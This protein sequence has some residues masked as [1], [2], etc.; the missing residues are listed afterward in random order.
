MPHLPTP[1]SRASRA[2][3]RPIGL[4]VLPSRRAR[5][6]WALFAS[7]TAAALCFTS[8]SHPL[9]PHPLWRGIAAAFAVAIGWQAGRAL[10][11]GGG[12]RAVR[13]LEWQAGG[14]WSLERAD[15]VREEARLT[16]ATATLG[17]WILLVWSVGASGWSPRSRRYALID[18]FEAG[19]E[20]FRALKGRLS[21]TRW[22][23]E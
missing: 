13:R 16:D 1:K 20:V 7:L 10:L 15:G 18:A 4:E 17:P 14:R 22:H 8:L 23:P 3:S 21:L 6:A 12:K 5:F 9:E 19:P 2:S 11:F